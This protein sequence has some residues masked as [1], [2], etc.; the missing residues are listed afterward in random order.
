MN[1][2]LVLSAITTNNAD[3][4]QQWL[5]VVRAASEHYNLDWRLMDALIYAESNW[6]PT[7]ESFKGAKGLT[8]LSPITIIHLNVK[9]P[10]DPEQ[11]IWAGAK[12][13]RQMYNMFGCWK[14]ALAAY[15]AGPN[16]VKKY[17]K[18]PPFKE[19]MEYVSKIILRWEEQ[20][21]NG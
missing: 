16:A 3:V 2:I 19:T 17:N 7:V 12:Y 20:S 10:N 11:S 5:P 1:F 13:L 9:N 8:Q 21:D 4:R 18:I 14:M 15:N 6:D